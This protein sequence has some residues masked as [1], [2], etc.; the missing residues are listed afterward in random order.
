MTEYFPT[1]TGEYPR[2][3]SNFWTT[4]DAKNIWRIINT[5]ARKELGF[6]SLDI[7]CSEKHTLFQEL[8]SS[9]TASF[10]E[11][12]MAVDKINIQAYFHTKWRLLFIC[13]ELYNRQN[14]I[15]ILTFTSGNYGKTWYPG[16]SV[17]LRFCWKCT[18]YCN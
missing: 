18:V 17:G 9:K 1:K 3:F 13:D 8:S 16:S 11:Q 5:I 7:I 6:L 2:I 14:M 10:K 4:C 15:P 12:I